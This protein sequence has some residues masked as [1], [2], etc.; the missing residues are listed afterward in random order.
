MTPM[1]MMKQGQPL[2]PW[3]HLELRVLPQPYEVP[4]LS[5][6]FC[7]MGRLGKGNLAS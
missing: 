6:H 7:K 1:R 4:L 2:S 3:Q 5:F